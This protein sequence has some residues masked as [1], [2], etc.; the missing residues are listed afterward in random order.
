MPLKNIL[1]EMLA[2]KTKPVCKWLS[3]DYDEICVNVD[4]PYVADFCP[5]VD[6]PRCCVHFEER[7]VTEDGTF[8]NDR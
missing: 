1:G 6:L 5:C 8:Q 4:S 7:E 2:E 3:D